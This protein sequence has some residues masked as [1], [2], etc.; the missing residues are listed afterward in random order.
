MVN[1]SPAT[2]PTSRFTSHTFCRVG[3]Q[4]RFVYVQPDRRWSL[5]MIKWWTGWG[6][7]E[8][9]EAL[10]QYVHDVTIQ[11]EESAL[12][13]CMASGKTCLHG[14]PSA[15]YEAC[16]G[17]TLCP[18]LRLTRYRTCTRKRSFF[19]LRLTILSSESIDLLK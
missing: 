8:S 13:D 1:R 3:A 10:V 17:S 9:T 11:S 5:R 16:N 14:S 4:Y 19:K 12:A 18:L 15:S 6:V 2:F 7:S